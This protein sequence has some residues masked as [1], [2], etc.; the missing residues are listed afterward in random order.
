MCDILLQRL[1]QD[2]GS[3][4]EATCEELRLLRT[5]LGRLECSFAK[6]EAKLD[7]H[8]AKLDILLDMMTAQTPVPQT[9]QCTP[10]T[11]AQPH[12]FATP[13]SIN[14][15][16]SSVE[17]PPPP[18]VPRQQEMP[19]GL[20]VFDVPAQRNALPELTDSTMETGKQCC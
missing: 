3:L 17:F 16:A 7:T 8:E 18:V 5:I 9:P 20:C 1:N 15:S 14:S 2:S 10:P 4:S 13:F 11:S 12:S 19:G 6:Q